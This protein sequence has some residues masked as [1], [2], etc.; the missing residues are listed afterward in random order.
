M[1]HAQML[2]T[3]TPARL[4]P[5]LSHGCQGPTF[6]QKG[7]KEQEEVQIRSSEE[8]GRR[9]KNIITSLVTKSRVI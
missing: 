5:A 7:C 9:R 3:L 6:L 1:L 4:P 2:T 8:G